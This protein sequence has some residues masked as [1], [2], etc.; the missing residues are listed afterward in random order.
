MNKKNTDILKL[1]RQNI[2]SLTPY[3]SARSEFKEQSNKHSHDVA[4]DP[5][6]TNIFLDANENALG[7]VFTESVDLSHSEWEVI[8]DEHKS[9]LAHLHRYPQSAHETLRT[10]ISALKNISNDKIFTG[11]GSDEAIDILIRMFCEPRVDAIAV[12]NPSYGMYQVA[13]DIQDVTTIKIDFEEDFSIDAEKILSALSANVKLLFL[14]SPNNPTGNLLD[15]RKIEYIL[16]QYPGIVVVDEAYIDFKPEGSV[17]RFLETYDNL[18]VLQTL[19]KAWGLA[20]L[21]IGMAFANSKIIDIMNKV[22]MPY[23]LSN[24]SLAIALFA[25]SKVEIKNRMV[26]EILSERAKL[27]KSLLTFPFVKKVYPSDANFLLVRFEPYLGKENQTSDSIF[28]FLHQKGIITRDRSKNRFCEGCLRIT[29]GTKKEN[30]LL[31]NALQEL[32]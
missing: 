26:D 24:I 16:D 2:A 27:Q 8:L 30:E 17:L 23:N 18:I 11:H 14:C 32:V 21:R 10:K 9:I 25:M 3:S 28:K 7:N 1:L 4:I 5:L 20:G 6:V 15:I 29:V 22:K 12:L 13:A 19:S 31:L